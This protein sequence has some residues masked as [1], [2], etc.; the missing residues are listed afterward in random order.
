MDTKKQIGIRIKDLR[1]VKGISQAVLAEACGIST[2]YVS[3]IERGKENPTLDLFMKISHALDVE[4]SELFTFSQEGMSD[5]ML[6]D[7][8]FSQIKNSDK[9]RLKLSAKIIKSI[10]S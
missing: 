9:E 7:F 10:Y 2:I 1:K 6:K 3:G 5:E 8:V 4:I